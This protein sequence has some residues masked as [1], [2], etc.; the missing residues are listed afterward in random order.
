MY[1]LSIPVQV[2][3]QCLMIINKTTRPA[4]GFIYKKRKDE[5]LILPL[6]GC[7]QG[8]SPCQACCVM[9]AVM[10]VL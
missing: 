5:L 9:K 8:I 1:A 4:S 10:I 2:V 7:N 3:R 6:R